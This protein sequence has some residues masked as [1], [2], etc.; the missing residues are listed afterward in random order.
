MLSDARLPNLSKLSVRLTSVFY[1]EQRR[2]L[3]FLNLYAPKLSELTLLGLEDLDALAESQ[4]LRPVQ[5]LTLILDDE[6]FDIGR[7]V[8]AR[9]RFGDRRVCVERYAL[10]PEE[11]QAL[12][13]AGFRCEA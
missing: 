7:L 11:V 8:S 3:R 10:T 2:D 6:D 5:T 1:P 13:E 9:P 12:R 4:L